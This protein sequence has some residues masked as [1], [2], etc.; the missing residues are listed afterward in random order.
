MSNI[1]LRPD[2]FP[3]VPDL[4][5][6]GVVSGN[7]GRSWGVS[8]SRTPRVWVPRAYQAEG[9]RP[10]RLRPSLGRVAPVGRSRAAPPVHSEISPKVR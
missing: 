8:R 6:S 9:C 1:M 5:A 10:T 3:D 2:W 7:H 4:T